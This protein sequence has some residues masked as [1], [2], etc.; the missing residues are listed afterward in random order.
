MKL[1][2]I[3]CRRCGMKIKGVRFRERTI[4]GWG[5]VESEHGVP[6]QPIFGIVPVVKC[7]CGHHNLN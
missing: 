5:G 1:Q 3:T 4:V 2:K 7:P 6:Q